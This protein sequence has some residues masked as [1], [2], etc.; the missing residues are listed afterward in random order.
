M[1]WDRCKAYLPY[2]KAAVEAGLP[3]KQVIF[4]DPSHK[5]YDFW[6]LR[7]IKAYHFA[8]AF[9]REGVPMWWDES[10]DVAFDVERRISRSRAAS[11]RAE[12]AESGKDKTPPPGRYYVPVPRSVGGKP[13]P[14]F[15]DWIEQQ[16]RKKG[17]K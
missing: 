9:V 16:E 6:D 4:D 15:A 3:P 17:K 13:M 11:D 7:L 5:E 10:D 1:T 8:E 12:K 2:I 14:T